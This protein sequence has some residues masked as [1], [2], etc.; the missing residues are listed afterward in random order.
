MALAGVRPRTALALAATVGGLLLVGVDAPVSTRRG[1]VVIA[2][3]GNLDGCTFRRYTFDS[4]TGP[5]VVILDGV[6]TIHS[7]VY[8]GDDDRSHLR[9]DAGH[10]PLVLT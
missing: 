10:V 6:D 8:S 1:G 5:L 4:L 3:L 9:S 2:V 7:Q